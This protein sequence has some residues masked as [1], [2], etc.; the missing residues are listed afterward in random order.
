MFLLLISKNFVRGWIYVMEIFS[1]ISF[2]SCPKIDKCNFLKFQLY[3]KVLQENRN[4]E[5][6]IDRQEYSLHKKSG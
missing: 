6:G 2:V 5:I 1:S 4:R 3:I